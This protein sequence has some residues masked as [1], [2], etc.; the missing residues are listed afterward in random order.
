MSP[1][2]TV[3]VPLLIGTASLTHGS[4]TPYRP[5]LWALTVPVVLDDTGQRR[6]PMMD[7]TIT[8]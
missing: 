5:G 6:T 2:A 7:L 4:A 1:A 8:E 3:R